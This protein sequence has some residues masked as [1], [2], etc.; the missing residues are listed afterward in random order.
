MPSSSS[1]NDAILLMPTLIMPTKY[2]ETEEENK[3]LNH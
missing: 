2:P 3:I 1:N